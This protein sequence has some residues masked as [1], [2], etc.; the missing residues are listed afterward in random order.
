MAKKDKFSVTITDKTF[1][2]DL[3]WMSY[4]YCIGRKTIAACTHADNIVKI[5]DNLSDE[6]RQFMAFDIRREINRVAG[7]SY[8]ITIEGY[9]DKYDVYSLI[10]KYIMAH[11][12]IEDD[13]KYQ[14]DVNV[15]TGEVTCTE[16]INPEKRY[17]ESILNAYTDMAP[18]IKLYSYMDSDK[19][20]NVNC[21]Y[22]GVE[23]NITCFEHMHVFC[24]DIRTLYMPIDKYKER[25]WSNIHVAAEYI[26]K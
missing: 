26:N 5:I 21:T 2:E 11:P 10:W 7:I 15:D 1:F 13:T 17:I 20:V 6:R 24:K 9:N 16:F 8:N 18:W 19:H 22:D 12:E 3:I 14:W 23:Q 25:P 4:R